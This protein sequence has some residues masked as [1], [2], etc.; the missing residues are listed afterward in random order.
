M[1]LLTDLEDTIL[2]FKNKFISRG[3][4]IANVVNNI[5]LRGACTSCKWA[6]LNG[7]LSSQNLT[8]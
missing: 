1:I 5:H 3:K 8:F 7:G 4:T 2:S 6:D